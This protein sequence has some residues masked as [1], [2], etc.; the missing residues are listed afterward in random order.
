MCL[1]PCPTLISGLSNAN[2]DMNEPN[3][4]IIR[5][6]RMI[7]SKQW[8]AHLW[9]LYHWL[10]ET[11]KLVQQDLLESSGP[12]ELFSDEFTSHQMRLYA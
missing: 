3:E 7:T 1:R 9:I 6:L 5:R 4:L 8:F 10:A 2:V 11:L 12:A